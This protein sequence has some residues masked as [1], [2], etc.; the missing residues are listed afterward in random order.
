MALATV[1]ARPLVSPLGRSPC[2]VTTRVS[3]R[4]VVT[5]P[6]PFSLSHARRSWV[7]VA[8]P[9]RPFTGLP[10]QR[11]GRGL[12]H[13][14]RSGVQAS[15]P[16]L[17]S[18]RKTNLEAVESE[19]ADDLCLHVHEKVKYCRVQRGEAATALHQ[20]LE[21]GFARPAAF[22]ISAGG[23]AL[24]AKAVVVESRDEFG[25]IVNWHRLSVWSMRRARTVELIHD[26]SLA[27][28][29]PPESIHDKAPEGKDARPKS[30]D[31]PA[32]TRW[33]RVW[34]RL[35]AGQHRDY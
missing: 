35:A 8:V 32:Q 16:T 25:N 33:D 34:C 3:V 30:L 1:Q 14:W 29:V 26:E 17:P 10:C 11:P 7:R 31:D 28:C 12:R 23:C 24:G 21:H 4:S 20:S 22:L 13:M 27:L 18:R 2:M 5:F 19:A 9:A 6:S 15:Q